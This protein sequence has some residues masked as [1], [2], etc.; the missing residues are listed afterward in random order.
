MKCYAHMKGIALCAATSEAMEGL[1]ITERVALPESQKWRP[2]LDTQ[3]RK[4]RKRQDHNKSSHSTPI[5]LSTC[6][7][8]QA[9]EL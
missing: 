2:G 3:L 5:L 6:V 1:N 4:A 7:F 8:W 9:S